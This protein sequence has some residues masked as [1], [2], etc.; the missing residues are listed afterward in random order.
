VDGE[1]LLNLCRNPS[2]STQLDLFGQ[3]IQVLFEDSIILVGAYFLSKVSAG[4]R[5]K[6]PWNGI[7]Q[8][9]CL[10]TK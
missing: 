8:F 6:H 2:P 4:H 10:P 7:R 5:L 1:N 3:P 9:C